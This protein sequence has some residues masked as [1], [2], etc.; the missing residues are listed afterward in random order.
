MQ[1]HLVS[2]E[3]PLYTGNIDMA[4]I[5]GAEGEFG[6]LP[7]HVLFVSTLKAGI[8]TINLESPTPIRWTG[9]RK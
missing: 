5:P 4:T 7:G 9:W 1:L 6:V 3:K 2:P 8:I